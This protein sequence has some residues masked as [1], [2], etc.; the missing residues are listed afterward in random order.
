MTA[1]ARALPPPRRAPGRS[2]L[3]AAL[4]LLAA[5][6]CGAPP[7]AVAL[8]PHPTLLLPAA[9]VRQPVAVF[10]GDSYTSGWNGVGSGS[11]GWAAAVAAALGAQKVNLAVAG[12]G[13]VRG[14]IHGGTEGQRVGRQLPA[15]IAAKPDFVF[16][17]AGLN[18][19]YS[20]RARVL[21]AAD[22]VVFRLRS[23]LPE[24]RIVII[25]PWWPKPG[26]TPPD[27][28]VAL[29]DRLRADAARI[30]AV[31]VDPYGGRWFAGANVRFI[32]PDH[33]HP[34]ST[35]HQFIARKVLLAISE[36]VR[37]QDAPTPSPSDGRRY[38]RS[39]LDPR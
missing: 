18:D 2:A 35:G 3:L 36:W 14:G 39:T 38:A 27:T 15:A 20:S 11:R 33:W 28:L 37:A 21:R 1:L 12:T 26:V 23:A 4:L 6:A 22:E 9:P 31:F 24:A 19:I 16:L 29:R 30:G 32:G 5:S 13:F 25:G 34:T 17:A 8:L 7:A 10:L